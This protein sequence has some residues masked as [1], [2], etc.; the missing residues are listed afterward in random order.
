MA[1]ETL[2]DIILRFYIEALF[3]E[4]SV[5]KE[6]KGG[7]LW[8]LETLLGIDTKIEEAEG[9]DDELGNLVGIR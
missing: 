3:S 2:E 9:V 5:A 6:L 4:N 8:E 1:I 7:E